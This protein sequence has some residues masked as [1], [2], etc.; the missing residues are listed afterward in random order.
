M[1]VV[2]KGIPIPY[3]AHPLEVMKRLSDIGVTDDVTLC[4]ALLHDVLEDADEKSRPFMR[5]TIKDEC[6]QDVLDVVEALTYYRDTGTKEEYIASFSEKSPEA[7]VVKVMDRI[8]NVLDFRA[9]G[10]EYAEKYAEKGLPIRDLIYRKSL[11]DKF[12]EDVIK[13][14]MSFSSQVWKI[15]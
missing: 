13:K 7:C 5:K 6:G 10:S 11:L 9:S 3:I 2:R 14:L 8:C 12:G 15:F 4:A 1:G